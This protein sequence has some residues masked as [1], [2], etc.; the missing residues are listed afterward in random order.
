MTK[1]P[2]LTVLGIYT[3]WKINTEENRAQSRWGS[4][5]GHYSI[6]ITIFN[7]FL[8]NSNNNL[9]DIL[10]NTADLFTE[11][12]ISNQQKD[13]HDNKKSAYYILYAIY[14]TFYFKKHFGEAIN[15]ECV[16]RPT[17]KLNN[18]HGSGLLHKLQWLSKP[19]E[20]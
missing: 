15:K 10:A 1:M 5:L 12:W 18:T 8:Y 11:Y 19:R 16:S 6:F 9:F 4:P 7:T 13:M 14:K 17:G 2:I 3:H 20:M